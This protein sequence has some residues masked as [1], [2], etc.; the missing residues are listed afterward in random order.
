MTQSVLAVRTS[1]E[2][3]VDLASVS[4]T[5]NADGGTV[6]V[7][8]ADQQIARHPFGRTTPSTRRAR[9]CVRFVPT[10]V[11][12]QPLKISFSRRFVSALNRTPRVY[13]DNISLRIV[14]GPTICIQGERKVGTSTAIDL[15]GQGNCAFAL[16]VAPKAAANA[17]QI[18][19][20]GG[21]LELDLAALQFLVS[22]ALDAQGSVRIPVRAPASL[23]GVALHWQAIQVCPTTKDFGAGV[24]IGFYR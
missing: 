12:R 16:F 15:T 10:K 24:A 6:E 7:F 2:F 8:L 5:N 13:A 18:P 3:F 20:F 19:G 14:R 9:L 11:G 1:M 23:A 21:T 17:I 4:T 22:G